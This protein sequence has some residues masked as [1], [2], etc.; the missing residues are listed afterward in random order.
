MKKI[1]NR[2]GLALKH[3]VAFAVD[4]VFPL[5]DLLEAVLLIIPIPQNKKIVDA[6][7]HLEL[8][9]IQWVNVLKQVKEVVEKVK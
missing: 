4:L 9:L 1:L 6:L 5:L 3:I 8:Q 2:I 7:E